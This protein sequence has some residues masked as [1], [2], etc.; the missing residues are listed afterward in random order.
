MDL[1]NKFLI[2][3][4]NREAI[5]AKKLAL[6]FEYFGYKVYLDNYDN[7]IKNKNN[8]SL[9][10]NISFLTINKNYDKEIKESI[11]TELVNKENI[12][13]YND[14]LDECNHLIFLISDKDIDELWFIYELT[15][16]EHINKDIYLFKIKNSFTFLPFP[17]KEKTLFENISDF[18]NLFTEILNDTFMMQTNLNYEIFILRRKEFLNYSQDFMLE[19]DNSFISSLFEIFDLDRK[20]NKID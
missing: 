17:L 4:K 13:K 3:Y 19:I 15:F 7:K 9:Q 18:F 2:S 1:I 16:A 20:K 11:N 6:F 5:K 10:K 14:A 8:E 12:K